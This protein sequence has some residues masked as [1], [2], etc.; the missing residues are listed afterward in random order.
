M[1]ASLAAAPA[2]LTA[3][4]VLQ[5]VNVVKEYPGVPP[6]RAVNRV[7]LDIRPGELVAIIG[8]SGSGKSTLMNILGTLDRPT[9][10]EV[11]IGGQRTRELSD[12]SMAGL[13]S[14]QIG[15]VFQQFHLIESLSSLDNV[16]TGLLYRGVRRSARR[17]LAEAALTRVG[18]EHRMH[19][20]P[21]LLSGGERQRVA[22]AR[23]IVGSPSV[24]LAD[25]PT[26]NLDSSNSR[27]T[28]NVLRRLHAEGATIV[29]ITH[30]HAIAD[31]FPRQIVVSDGQII[32]DTNR[33]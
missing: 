23:A 31:S 9:A 24:I 2:D 22:I 30:D 27:E 8:S 12:A 25:E 3:T 7:S 17:R 4:P 6:V 5:L 32:E 10:G 21:P 14:A 19:H 33:S 15:F 29:V 26:G 11:L 13:R 1:T 20:R 18:L 28:I 16:A